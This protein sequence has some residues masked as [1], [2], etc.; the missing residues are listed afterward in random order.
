[1]P[2]FKDDNDKVKFPNLPEKLRTI[3]FKLEIH[4]IIERLDSGIKFH[5][6]QYEQLENEM[7]SYLSQVENDFIKEIYDTIKADHP[8]TG[9]IKT[10]SVPCSYQDLLVIYQFHFSLEDP[11]ILSAKNKK[12][13]EEKNESGVSGVSAPQHEMGV[14]SRKLDFEDLFKWLEEKK[15]EYC[16][17]ISKSDRDHNIQIKG[18]LNVNGTTFKKIVR[19]LNLSFSPKNG[20]I[21]IVH[22]KGDKDN[23]LY[24]AWQLTNTGHNDFWIKDELTW[25]LFIQNLQKKLEPC[26]LTPEEF[27]ELLE[28]LKDVKDDQLVFQLETAN[29]IG[30]RDVIKKLFNKA[31]LIYRR[32]RHRG[33]YFPVLVKIDKSKG[34]YEIEFIGPHGP[35]R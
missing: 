11:L 13:L 25:E 10:I 4:G 33:R 21:T 26:N 16:I 17:W 5:V 19:G 28:C 20:R 27:K 14:E 30:P 2:K 3:I 18:N 9:Y 7:L 22:S 32:V 24:F 23:G 6:K 12:F 8:D 35:T 31:C 29:L 15:W 34:P 1:M